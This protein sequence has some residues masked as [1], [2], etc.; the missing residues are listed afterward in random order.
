MSIQLNKAYKV[1]YELIKFLEQNDIK[2][3]KLRFYTDIIKIIVSY[4][5]EFSTTTKQTGK[6][7]KIF[8]N[9]V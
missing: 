8:D 6:R 7:L 3:T 4:S 1:F 2:K 5:Y 9:K